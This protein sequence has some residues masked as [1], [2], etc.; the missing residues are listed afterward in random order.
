VHPP[1]IVSEFV[2]ILGVSRTRG[3]SKLG[4]KGKKGVGDG[5]E[6]GIRLCDP[7]EELIVTDGIK[8]ISESCGVVGV[9]NPIKGSG[10]DFIVDDGEVFVSHIDCILASGSFN[11]LGVMIDEEMS[12]LGGNSTVLDR[13]EWVGRGGNGESGGRH[14]EVEITRMRVERRGCCFS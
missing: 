4:K 12:V 14:V 7:K 9:I 11:K 10:E 8:E 5:K 13:E 3:S 6:A 2:D 1:H